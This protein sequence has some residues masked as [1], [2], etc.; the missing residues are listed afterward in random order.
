[1]CTAAV[2]AEARRLVSNSYSEARFASLTSKNAQ[3]VFKAAV[4]QAEH[5]VKNR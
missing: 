1:M 4:R 2:F 3:I 5:T